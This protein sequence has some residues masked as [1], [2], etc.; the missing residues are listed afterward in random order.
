MTTMSRREKL[1]GAF[2]LIE[3]LVVI[4]II[5]ILAAML[6]PVLAKAKRKA[7]GAA[8]LSNQKQLGLA[9]LMYA[10][11]NQGLLINFDTALHADGTRPWR[12]AIPKPPPTIPPS[13][14]GQAQDTLILQQGFMQGGLYQYTPNV[15]ILHCPADLR[16]NSPYNPSASTPPGSFA[17]GSYSG[18]A[19]M[20]GSPNSPSTATTKQSG[21]AHPSQRYLWIEENDPRGENEGAWVMG[22]AGTPPAFTD[23]TFEDSVASWHGDTSTFSWADGHAEIHRWLDPA[24]IT[25]ALS[26]NPNKYYSAPPTYTQCPHDLNFLANG[27]ATQQNP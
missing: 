26:M 16:A 11:D 22:D 23:A 15:N 27:Y 3:L 6:L 13:S 7:M 25:Y 12:F 20:N 19:A 1:C 21:I 18:S 17:W 4:A 2:T 9:W 14:S 24:T 5:A 10:D 8:C